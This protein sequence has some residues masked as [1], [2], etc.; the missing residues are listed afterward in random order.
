MKKLLSLLLALTKAL[1][2]SACG[3]TP[4]PAPAGSS[5]ASSSG[6]SAAASSAASSSGEDALVPTL[7]QCGD[8]ITNDFFDMSLDSVELAD[9][10]TYRTS[11]YSSTSLYVEEGY[12]LI[13]LKGHM[14]N[15][16]TSAISSNQLYLSAVVNGNYEKEGSDVSI[17]F[18]RDKYFEI[19]A[20]TDID[21]VI[22]LN[23]PEKLAAQLDTVSF[24]LRYNADLSD[25]SQ[26][27]SSD[28][29]LTLNADTAYQL[30]YKF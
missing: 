1:T 14:E 27:Y 9:E 25:V 23:V 15:K 11:E 30:D 20:Y 12:K 13:L 8:H 2:L 10:Y 18:L 6:G 24:T 7:V 28:G 26:V 16:G 4:A 21:Y 5:G 19:D 17:H 3:S 29:T 22:S